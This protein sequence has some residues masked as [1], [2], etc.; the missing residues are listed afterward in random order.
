MKLWIK[1]NQIEIILFFLLWFTYG[2]FVHQNPGWNVTTRMDLVYALVDRGTLAIDA[3]YNQPAR[4]YLT[5]DVA[6]FNGKHYSDKAPGLALLGVPV[7]AGFANVAD[8]LGFR[9]SPTVARWIVTWFTVG[10]LSALLGV[11]LYWFLAFFEENRTTRLILVLAYALGTIAFP[12][13]TLFISHQAAACFAFLGFYLIFYAIRNPQSA[14]RNLIFAG[15]LAGYSLITEYPVGIILIGLMVYLFSKL[16][17][18]RY[19]ILFGLPILGCLLIPAFIN[20]LQFGSP[21]ALGY[22]YEKLD[23]FR[24]GMSR[25]LFGITVPSLKILYGIT[26]HPFRGLFFWSPVLILA[27][28][29]FYYLYQEEKFRKE[30]WLFLYIIVAFFLFNM[31]YFAWWGGWATGPRHLIP[32][33]PFLIIPMVYI[34]RQWRKIQLSLTV[35]SIT[36]M[37]IATAADPQVPQTYL[38]PL[39]EFAIP[40]LVQGHLTLNLGNILFGLTGLSSLIPLIVILLIGTYL[41]FKTVKA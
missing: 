6:E 24:T 22:Q 26:I 7:N 13:S 19:L 17:K 20:H 27:I 5:G 41:L 25:G 15:L 9:F 14:I 34:F 2:Y 29:G 12:Y 38:Y 1:N 35:I 40:R 36:L 23:E 21:F 10:L 33:L 39:W 28:F 11:F 30:F 4:E 32:M 3:Y 8:L 31:A 16:K 18:I 37:F